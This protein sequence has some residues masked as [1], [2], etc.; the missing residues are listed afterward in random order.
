MVIIVFGRQLVRVFVNLGLR[1][2]FAP[3]F[4]IKTQFHSWAKEITDQNAVKSVVAQMA[5]AV[6]THVKIGQHSVKAPLLN[7]I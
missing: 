6:Q 1:R 4:K 7:T 5:K 3:H 2:I